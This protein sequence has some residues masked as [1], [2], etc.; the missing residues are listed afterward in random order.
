MWMLL[1]WGNKH[2]FPEGPSV[3]IIDRRTGARAEPILVDRMT[4]RHISE[5]EFCS[6]PVPAADERTRRRY[7]R[8]GRAS[9][10]SRPPEGGSEPRAQTRRR[11]AA[12][13][14]A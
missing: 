9:I 1:T 7:A 4:G 3:V 8:S 14:R 11:P 2:F 6:A 5:S 12:R 13:K 10:E